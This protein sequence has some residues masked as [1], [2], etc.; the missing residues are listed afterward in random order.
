MARNRIVE[1]SAIL[2]IIGSE[3]DLTRTSNFVGF[4]PQRT[5]KHRLPKVETAIAVPKTCC[6]AFWSDGFFVRC[7]RGG[8]P[9]TSVYLANKATPQSSME[10][11]SF[12]D[13][14]YVEIFVLLKP[15]FHKTLGEFRIARW[16][17]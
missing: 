2:I 8:A 15:S 17:M 11:T 16:R 5:S 10:P 13:P 7:L 14:L 9:W 1:T 3:A 4:D 6:N 12:I